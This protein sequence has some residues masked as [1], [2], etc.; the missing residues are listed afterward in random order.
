MNRIIAALL[1]LLLLAPPAAAQSPRKV[2]LSA[3]DAS[4]Q[5]IVSQNRLDGASLWVSHNGNTVLTSH[6]GSFGPQSR[7]A[8]ASASKWVSA[9]VLA[10]L[11]ERGTLRWDST[12]GE[13]FPGVAAD[14]AGITLGQLF[15][16]TSGLPGEESGCIANAFITLQDCAAQILAG[17]M[18]AAPGAA[19]AY[20]GLSMQVAGAMAERAS[21]R[22]WNTL[23]AQ[24]L[25]E[26]LGLTQ[27]DFGSTSTSPGLI[28]LPNPRIAGGIRSTLEDYRRLMAMWQADG[29]V[30]EGPLAGQRFL[31]PA[32]LRAMQVDR[33][34]GAVRIDVPPSVAG[35]SFGY[36]F[37]FWILPTGRA[38]NPVIE[39][40]PGAFGFQGWVDGAAGIAGVFMVLDSNVRVSSDVRALQQQ[41]ASLLEFRRNTNSVAGDALGLE[42]AMDVL[43]AEVAP[44]GASLSVIAGQHAVVRMDRGDA[45]AQTRIPVD[46]ASSWAS[47][48]VFARLV[49]RG[50]LRWDTRVGE[51]F[52]EAATQRRAITLEQLLSHTSG[53]PVHARGCVAQ[54]FDSLQRCAREILSRPVIAAPGKV[55]AY[56]PQSM[57]VAAA[58]AERASGLAWDELFRREVAD[59]LGLLASDYRGTLAP[60]QDRDVP[61]PR[62]ADGLHSSVADYSRIVA[63]WT[64]GGRVG[65]RLFLQP[66]TLRAM[67][68]DRTAGLA[69]RRPPPGTALYPAY[70]YGLGLLTLPSGRAGNPIRV[71]SPGARGFTPWADISAGTGG[72]LM[73]R[74]AS[75]SAAPY[76]KAIM[77]IGAG[78]R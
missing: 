61:N 14:K 19:F 3:V 62:V 28:T 27:T 34:A 45:S 21:G 42:S 10:R 23:F 49:E 69:R 35:A 39:S 1:A 20:G 40:S 26:P 63:M 6:Y 12:V 11:V 36:G 25:T 75:P 72:V 22:G 57:Q 68:R 77:E 30:K 78:S 2:D 5:R 56:G 41:L 67:E 18:V 43:V 8:I 71:A 9:L 51:W 31:Q 4:M 37:G 17:P 74:E 29:L 64:E 46:A 60:T 54:P 53:L 32:T 38:G 52:P 13:W 55:F 48:L 50:V 66:S 59:P 76:V 44:K 16:H 65:E 73:V 7:V 24:E 70:G 47:A 58:M 15:S 33:S